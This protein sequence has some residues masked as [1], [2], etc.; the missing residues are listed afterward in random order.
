MLE[1]V[2]LGQTRFA[3]PGITV[4][5]RGIAVGRYGLLLFPA[6]DG[7]VGWLRL[8]SDE[9]GLEDVLAEL[10]I[11]RVKSAVGAR[12][13]ALLVPA[14]TSYVLDRAARCAQLWGGR[15]FTGTAR[16]FVR[17]RD[18]KS[19]YGYDVVDAT[20]VQGDGDLIL[21]GEDGS[22]AYRKDGS[23]DVRS[24]VFRLSPVRVPGGERL[25]A[26][27]RAQLWLTVPAGLAPGVVRY[28]WKNRVATH[29]TTIALAGES[30]SEFAVPGTPEGHLLARVADLPERILASFLG[31]PGVAFYRPI[32]EQVA[33][34][35]GWRH[36][37][38]LSSCATLFDAQKL[39]LF[40]GQHDRVWVVAGPVE[41]AD[42]R[43]LTQ[44]RLPEGPPRELAADTRAAGTVGLALRLAPTL[45]APRRVVGTLIAWDEAP[46]L[47]KLVYALPPALL[48]GHRMVPSERG[49]LL[50]ADDNVDVI[51]LGTLLAELAPGL[52]LPLGMDLEP[53]VAPDVVAEALG[54]GPGRLTVFPH[55]GA[56]F[57]VAE[58][59]LRPLERRALAALAVP[60][61]AAR[62][63]SVATPGEPPRVVNDAVGAFAL[64]GYPAPAKPSKPAP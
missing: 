59:E 13:F 49:L 18:E 6:L 44:V 51:P 55:E 33:V 25:D 15:S 2:A 52:L 38:E 60:R 7:A 36:P 12:A 28:L 24:L 61:A 11:W 17:Y 43:H 54:H 35:V 32:T 31:I 42:A 4:D 45:T 20:A 58:S 5:A 57:H 10:Q 8:Y 26:E 63:L 29:V 50:V 16:H 9:A 48:R 21:H 46:R 19:P 23:L 3:T 30:Q 22:A 47:K 41:L 27:G 53:R 62:D 14:S 56:P 37:I 64:W 1:R 40:S 39:Y 34:E